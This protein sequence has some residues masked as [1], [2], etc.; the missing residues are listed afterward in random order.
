MA[1][2]QTS[3]NALEKVDPDKARDR[4]MAAALAYGGVRQK[5]AMALDVSGPTLYRA[6]IRLKLKDRITQIALETKAGVSHG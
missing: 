2:E 4:I 3:L 5:M 6:I 1:G